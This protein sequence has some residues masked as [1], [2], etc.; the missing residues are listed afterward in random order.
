MSEDQFMSS[1]LCLLRGWALQVV[2]DLPFRFWLSE[3]GDVV[4]LLEQ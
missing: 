4:M 1:M 2:W 3:T